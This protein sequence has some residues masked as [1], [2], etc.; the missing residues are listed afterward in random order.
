M[1]AGRPEIRL[2]EAEFIAR[3]QPERHSDGSYYVQRDWT[4]PREWALI[5]EADAANRLWTCVNDGAGNDGIVQGLLH[6]NREFYII[7]AVP[8][9][10]RERYSV[11][12]DVDFCTICGE[13][14]A[15]TVPEDEEEVVTRSELEPDVCVSCHDR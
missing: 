1:R 2:S 8:Y 12:S 9:A 14:F 10:D 4:D 11:I 3:F 5:Q 13:R 6:V 15:D 7:C